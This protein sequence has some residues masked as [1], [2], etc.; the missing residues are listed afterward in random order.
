MPAT[1]TTTKDTPMT[2]RQAEIFAYLQD[3]Q[4]KS[5]I[6]SIREIGQQFGI[7]SPNGVMCHL[8]ALEKRGLLSREPGLARCL[9]VT[10]PVDKNAPLLT[11]PVVGTIGTG[12]KSGEAGTFDLSP[13]ASHATSVF[14]VKQPLSSS[15]MV[16]EAGDCLF[17]QSISAD[18]AARKKHV[19]LLASKTAV[20]IVKG[21]P[22]PLDAGENVLGRIIGVVKAI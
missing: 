15:E 2:Q 1:T 18:P 9:R 12:V 4:R 8:R 17:V 13:F 6:P 14:K 21:L 7:N 22:T 16:L 11:P 3:C 20:R 5:R 10:M 19:H